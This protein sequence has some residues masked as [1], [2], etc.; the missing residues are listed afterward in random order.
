MTDQIAVQNLHK[1]FGPRPQAAHDL[2]ERGLKKDAIFQ[3]TRSTIGVRD[4]SFTIWSGEIEEQTSETKR[5]P[6]INDDCIILKD[7]R[8]GT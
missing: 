2:L 7:R 6:T 1:I 8:Y 3:Q 4:A 5:C